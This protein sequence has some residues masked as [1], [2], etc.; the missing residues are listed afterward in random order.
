M[1]KLRQV[2]AETMHE[3]ENIYVSQVM[4]SVAVPIA[5]QTLAQN[6]EQP[7]KTIPIKGK[8]AHV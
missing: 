4:R 2:F 5:G 8:K 6:N 1:K 7:A 3:I